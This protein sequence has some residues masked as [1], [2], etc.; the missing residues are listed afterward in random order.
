M[1]DDKCIL[2]TGG[3]SLGSELTSQL[4][5]INHSSLRIFDH[6][7]KGLYKCEL[8]FRKDPRISYILGDVGDYDAVEMAL[9]GVNLLIHTAALK[10]V[11]Y[12]EN[13]PIKAIRT[14]IQGT[15]NIVEAA[16]RE[17]SVEKAI[18]I[19]SDKAC[20]PCNV[21]GITKAMQERLFTW[22]SRVSPK[23]FCTIRFPNFLGSNGSVIEIWKKQVV[24]GKPLSITDERMARYF[25]DISDAATRTLQALNKAEGGEIYIPAD[26]EEMNL[27]DLAKEYGEDFEIIGMRP[28]ERLRE[29]LLTEAEKDV[30]IKEDNLWKIKDLNLCARAHQPLQARWQSSGDCS[31]ARPV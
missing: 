16:L 8:K 6:S 5:D 9:S 15:I 28:G 2:I 29:V 23:V 13:Y 27:M 10:F 14:N 11:D 1:F 24:E 31:P 18:V 26:L 12:A 17:H 30:V 7:P 22:A 25:I 21:Y 3:G 19:S 20:N 4:Q